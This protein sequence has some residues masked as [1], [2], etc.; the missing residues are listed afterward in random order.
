MSIK[1]YIEALRGK[2]FEVRGAWA[3][4]N[5]INSFEDL[6]VNEYIFG[7]S[8]IEHFDN[9]KCFAE[10]VGLWVDYDDL[11]EAAQ[12]DVKHYND[13]S[14]QVT[15]TDAQYKKYR[16]GELSWHDIPEKMEKILSGLKV[17]TTLGG[18]VE[19][20]ILKN[21]KLIETLRLEA[22][23]RAI[24]WIADNSESYKDSDVDT[25]VSTLTRYSLAS[26]LSCDYMNKRL[27]REFWVCLNKNLNF[28]VDYADFLAVVGDIT[29]TMV[30]EKSEE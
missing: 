26:L 9:D 12:R 14:V 15:L 16:K 18:E 5:G 3:G 20:F 27:F 30:L 23:R 13:T 17:D 6:H 4:Y 24:R 28:V 8:R 7:Y 25:T 11:F 10:D 22:T 1:S 19:Q 2:I 21:E 29:S